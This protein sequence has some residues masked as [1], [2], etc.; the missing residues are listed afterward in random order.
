MKICVACANA[1][2]FESFLVARSGGKMSNLS[3]CRECRLSETRSR[4]RR[5]YYA[6]PAR[7][8]RDSNSYY[9]A[10]REAVLPRQNA[11]AALHRER[12]RIKCRAW[13]VKK[14][15]ARGRVVVPRVT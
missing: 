4:K 11:Y 3:K 13:Y 6:D 2:P 5:W 1:R 14:Q 12:N 9:Y 15:A 7:A 10:N 8:R